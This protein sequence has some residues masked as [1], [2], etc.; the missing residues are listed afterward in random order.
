MVNGDI[1]DLTSCHQACQGVDHVIHLAAL[2]SVPRSIAEP[3]VCHECNVTGFLNVLIAARDAKVKRLVYA[4]SSAIYGDDP[5]LPK[6]E[7]KIGQPLSPYAA[8]KLMNEIY[9]EGFCHGLSV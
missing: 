7:D 2:G 4:S 5:G 6:V 1:R 8:T 3:I 9:A